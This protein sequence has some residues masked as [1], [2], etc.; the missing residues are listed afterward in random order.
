MADR[1]T[2][3]PTRNAGAVTTHDP[4]VAQGGAPPTGQKPRR[5]LIGVGRALGP[6]IGLTLERIIDWTKMGGSS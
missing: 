6:W 5:T 4:A 3:D 2:N 1:W